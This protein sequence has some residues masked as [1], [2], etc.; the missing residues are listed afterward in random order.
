[1]QPP[2]TVIP[3]RPGVAKGSSPQ[4]VRADARGAASISVTP[5]TLHRRDPQRTTDSRLVAL[6]NESTVADMSRHQNRSKTTQ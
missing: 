1:V 5:T 3:H 6:Q 4:L 2:S